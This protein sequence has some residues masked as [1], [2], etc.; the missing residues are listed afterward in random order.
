MTEFDSETQQSLDQLDEL[1]GQLKEKVS[2][3]REGEF[4]ATALETRLRELTDLAA[5]AASTLESVSR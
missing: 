5:R 2:S 3:L 1:I 4:D